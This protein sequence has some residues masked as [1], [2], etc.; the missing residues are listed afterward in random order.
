MFIH[1]LLVNS[2]I[3]SKLIQSQV[4]VVHGISQSYE[5]PIEK[6]E[7]DSVDGLT[8]E[9]KNIDY[10]KDSIKFSNLDNIF[11]NNMVTSFWRVIQIR[12]N[13]W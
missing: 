1:F 2:A 10:Y 13:I 8:P 3:A 4:F 7:A 9:G 12:I 5:N 6:I 11:P